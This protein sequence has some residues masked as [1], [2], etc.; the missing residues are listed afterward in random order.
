MGRPTPLIL[1]VEDTRDDEQLAI[2]ALQQAEVNCVIAVARD[3]E[4]ALSLLHGGES[5]RN[6]PQVVLLDLKLPKV[7]GMEV[8]KTIRAHERTAALP[9]VILSSSDEIS[10]ID[11]CYEYGANSYIQKPVDFM[12]FVETV[13]QVGGYWLGLNR[14]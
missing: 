7:S 9:V 10:D 11:R 14:A 4:E 6:L 5:V 3:G 12:E 2:R 13:R 1:L 8:L